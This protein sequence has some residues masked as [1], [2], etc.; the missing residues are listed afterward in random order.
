MSVG[1]RYC[2]FSAY[3]L[4][5]LGYMLDEVLVPKHKVQSSVTSDG[6]PYII[7]DFERTTSDA[8][9]GNKR[10]EE[11]SRPCDLVARRTNRESVSGR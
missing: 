7:G 6:T 5:N 10:K 2:I 3:V 11:I 1:V 8:I 9:R 4:Y